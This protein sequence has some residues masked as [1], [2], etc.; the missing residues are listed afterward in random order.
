MTATNNLYPDFESRWQAL[1]ARD[2]KAAKCFLY[3]V[4]STGI[5]CRPT[6]AA[7]L[8]R[9][10]N[11]I[12]YD[13]IGEAEEAGFRPCKRCK[14]MLPLHESHHSIIR[15]TCKLLDNSPNGA[16][17]LKVLAENVGFTQWHFH[18]IFRK[19]TG[20]TP[21]MYWEA[22]H[23]PNKQI[24]QKLSNVD[25]N[26]LIAKISQLDENTVIDHDLI[27]SSYSRS[28]SMVKP[29][30]IV[31]KPDSKVVSEEAISWDS[32]QSSLPSPTS[33]LDFSLNTNSTGFLHGSLDEED[34]KFLSN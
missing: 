5:Y 14:P 8:A 17:H 19:F 13:T 33:E 10:K 15:E 11:V 18:R 3:C 29:R 23:S 6:C 21:R 28:N 25:L 20:I 24:K 4:K 26:E 7:R 27:K 34:E 2:P 22:R 31:A 1:I 12:F 16:P 32:A 9:K 30:P